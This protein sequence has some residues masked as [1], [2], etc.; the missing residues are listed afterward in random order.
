MLKFFFPLFF[1]LFIITCDDK[2]AP[3]TYSIKKA[4]SSNNNQSNIQKSNKINFFWNVPDNWIKTKG[5]NFAV[6]TY[7]INESTKISITEFP[8]LAGGIKDNVN[9]WRKQVNLPTQNIDQINNE[10]KIYS[11][12][13][14]EFSMHKISNVENPDLAFLCVIMPLQ[15]STVFVKLESSIEGLNESENI[16]LDFCSSFEYIK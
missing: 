7:S 14:T 6:A 8:G 3:R 15:Q 12:S 5:N 4:H 16:F 1:M 2:A 13:M 9:R 11:N 10:S